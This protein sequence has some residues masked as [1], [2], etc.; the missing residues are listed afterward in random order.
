[1][2]LRPCLSVAQ[3]ELIHRNA[4]RVLAEIGVRVE[5]AKVREAL[6]VKVAE[7]PAQALPAILGNIARTY[8]LSHGIE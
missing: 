8:P 2:R 1:M 6:A 5:H 3:V 7:I 4:L